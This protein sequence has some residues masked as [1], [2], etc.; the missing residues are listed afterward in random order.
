MA[1]FNLGTTLRTSMAGAI[2]IAGG[3]TAT[4]KIFSG[5][6]PVNCAASDPTGTL[7]TIDLPSTFLTSSGG[8]ASMTGTWAGTGSGDGDAASFRI[9]ASDGATC[10][11]QG[12]CTNNAGSG[13]M[14]LVNVNIATDQPIS[15]TSCTFTIGGA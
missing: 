7:C 14:K 3:A 9:Y 15:I 10:I 6:C 8:V 2:Q 11:A 1:A 5:A 13:T 4:L 12:D